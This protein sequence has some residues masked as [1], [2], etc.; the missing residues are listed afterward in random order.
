MCSMALGAVLIYTSSTRVKGYAVHATV[1]AMT[2]GE[3]GW[4]ALDRAHGPPEAERCAACFIPSQDQGSRYGLARKRGCE[5]MIQKPFT[6][7]KDLYPVSGSAAL[8]LGY[9]AFIS[10]CIRATDFECDLI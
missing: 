6:E 4:V 1:I 10:P 5:A 7:E 3:T 2:H 9:S 8:T